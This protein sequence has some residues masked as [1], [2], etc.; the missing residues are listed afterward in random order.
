M[1]VFCQGTPSHTIGCRAVA[2]IEK[3]FFGFLTARMLLYNGIAAS[4]SR[5]CPP[6]CLPARV[7][8]LSVAV[9]KCDDVASAGWW[10]GVAATV[11]TR[12]VILIHPLFASPN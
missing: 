3:V 6:K 12:L 10:Q 8:P 4:Q 5:K 7:F 1:M 11:T 9:Y 2:N